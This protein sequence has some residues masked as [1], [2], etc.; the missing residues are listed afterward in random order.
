ISAYV[1]TGEPLQCAGA[2]ALE[3]KGGLWVERLTGCPSNVIGL[4][5]PLL[6]EM[7]QH[8]GY[9]LTQYWESKVLQTSSQDC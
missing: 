3:G 4:S 1:Q 9:D 6:R 7:M 5:L 8:L 2:F